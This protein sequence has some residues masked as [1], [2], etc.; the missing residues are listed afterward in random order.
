MAIQ[1]QG[2]GGTV[3]EVQGTTFRSLVTF[4]AP[5]DHGALGHYRNALNSGTIASATNGVLYGFRWSDATRL[6]LVYKVA[7]SAGVVGASTTSGLCGWEMAVGRTW[8]SMYNSGGSATL[9]GNNG[10]LRTSMGSSLVAA[11][12]VRISST[13]SL[14]A[15]GTVTL[16]TNGMANVFVN[17]GSGTTTA[18]QAG[19]ILLPRYGLFDSDGEGQHPLV[20]AQNEGFVIR[21]TAAT[22][23]GLTYTIGVNVTWAEVT[24][25]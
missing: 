19:A 6:C 17:V 10:K 14:S 16:D 24:S 22:P 7:L 2:Q 18:Y 23:A 8:T 3:A 5:V 11:G 20:L 12:D 1:I 13:T 21:T 9:T 25:F 4:R 15:G